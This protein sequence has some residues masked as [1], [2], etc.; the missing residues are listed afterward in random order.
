MGEHGALGRL[1]R[2]PLYNTAAVAQATG[3]PADTFRAWER[4]Y[5]LPRPSRTPANQRLYS[6]RDIAV[7]NWLRQ[8]T[9]EGMTISR[10]IQRLRLESPEVFVSEAATEPAAEPDTEPQAARLRQRFIEASATFDSHRAEMVLDEALARF[11]IEAF[12]SKVVEPVLVE[13]GD[14]WSRD[15][16][17]VAAEHFA[18]RLLVYRLTA[19]CTSVAP[20]VA[21]GTTLAACPAGEEHEI[22]LL[23]LAVAFARRGWRV[24]QLG[25]DVPARDIIHATRVVRPDLVCLSASAERTASDAVVVARGIQADSGAPPL[26]ALGGRSVAFAGA[27]RAMPNVHVISGSAST[28]VDRLIDLVDRH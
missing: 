19:L 11:S 17:R 21:R 4:R 9:S 8:R 12:C 18:T 28:G 14:R 5:G 24:V 7:V 10:A 22:G 3:V 27:H 2:E 20:I 6:E 15:E 26:V 23:V 1:A 25:A 13:I 16:L